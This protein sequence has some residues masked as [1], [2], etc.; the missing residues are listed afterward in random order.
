[1]FGRSPAVS[2]VLNVP[3]SRSSVMTTMMLGLAAADT[4]EGVTAA[5]SQRG[6]E[7]R[8]NGTDAARPTRASVAAR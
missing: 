6:R 4:T 2:I 3:I 5:G 7:V 1:M 8:E